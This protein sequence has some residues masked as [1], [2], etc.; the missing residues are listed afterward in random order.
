MGGTGEFS[1]MRATCDALGTDFRYGCGATHCG[2][3]NDGGLLS[4]RCG[5][6]VV[7]GAHGSV[8]LLG[9]T[10]SCRTAGR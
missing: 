6:W 9:N 10:I 4:L 8:R 1:V 5:E 7:V 3:E 2:D